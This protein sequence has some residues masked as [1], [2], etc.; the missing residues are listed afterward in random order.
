MR[1]TIGWISARDPDGRFAAV[2][3][4]LGGDLA[5]G[6]DRMVRIAGIELSLAGYGIDVA[7][8]AQQM[9]APDNAPMRNSTRREVTDDDLP[10]L[11]RMVLQQG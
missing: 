9:A 3:A 2:A 1:A 10:V 7:S 5:A 11:A 8:L 6:F 4:L